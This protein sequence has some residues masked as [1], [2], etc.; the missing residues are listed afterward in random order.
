MF[1]HLGGTS[2]QPAERKAF[3]ALAAE[4]RKKGPAWYDPWSDEISPSFAAHASALGEACAVLARLLAPL[5]D[6]PSAA[7]V[8]GYL[9]DRELRRH[10]LS[11]EAL[12]FEALAAE[13]A[14]RG[15]IVAAVDEAFRKRIELF[16][17]KEFE[18]LAKG[19][20]RCLRL[21]ALC[22]YDFDGL[23]GCFAAAGG[24]RRSAAGAEAAE[25]IDDLRFLVDGFAWGAETEEL[26]D[27]LESGAAKDPAGKAKDG[28]R[29]AEAL[30]RIGALLAGP[31]APASLGAVVRAATLKLATE[32]R[33]WTERHDLRKATVDALLADYKEKR[34]TLMGRMAAAELE[35]KKKAL[36]GDE[37]LLQV[38]GYSDDRNELFS[39]HQLPRFSYVLP[40][41]IVKT[42]VE[43]KLVS[44]VREPVSAFQLVLECS[45]T[46][47]KDS[48]SSSIYAIT[49]LRNRVTAFESDILSP[50][51]SPLPE[52][53]KALTTAF[54]DNAGKRIAAKAIEGADKEADS[55][56]Q[57]AFKASAELHVCI[58]QVLVDLKSSHPLLVQNARSL[59]AGHPE[60]VTG[61]EVTAKLLFDFLKLLRNF[62]VDTRK[63]RE[64]LG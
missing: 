53:I 57:E 31:L 21:A 37:Q 33:G 39:E 61:L 22:R 49:T 14:E 45:S 41:R 30:G 58:E 11:L 59:V 64:L 51:R 17:S 15:D 42:F 16:R 7:R 48:L 1:V 54:L 38:Q 26:L 36:F 29:A 32:P 4:I 20:D 18:D 24:K 27:A 10:G 13:F 52:S 46:D 2:A 44:M 12:G 3:A 40:L 23:L 62:A 28:G 47:F 43:T 63:S 60:I 56:V 35:G 6:R 9:L 25:A 50:A 5:A 8:E 19:Y 34:L 55:I